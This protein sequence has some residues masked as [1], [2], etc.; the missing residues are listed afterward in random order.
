MLNIAYGHRFGCGRFGS[1]ASFCDTVT[2]PV[3]VM[4]WGM[5]R[6]GT[7]KVAFHL[8]LGNLP[9]TFTPPCNFSVR[10]TGSSSSTS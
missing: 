10:R 1:K 9:F 2:I 8:H 6:F 3:E 4:N 5:G 7:T